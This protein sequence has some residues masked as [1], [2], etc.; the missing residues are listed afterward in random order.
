MKVEHIRNILLKCDSIQDAIELIAGDDEELRE[1]LG[2]L[3]S[4]EFDEGVVHGFNLGR[5]CI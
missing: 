3:A 2:R 1:H 4:E 5:N